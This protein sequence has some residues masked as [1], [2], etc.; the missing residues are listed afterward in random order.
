[1][2][3]TTAG[4]EKFCP[5]LGAKA[6]YQLHCTETELLASHHHHH[7]DNHHHHHHHTW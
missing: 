1:M 5:K 4:P 2:D 3:P 7:D 6:N